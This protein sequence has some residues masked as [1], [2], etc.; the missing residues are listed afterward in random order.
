MAWYAKLNVAAVFGIHLVTR[1]SMF[2]RQFDP[3]DKVNW[4]HLCKNGFVIQLFK[5]LRKSD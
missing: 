4:N 5:G 3:I 2:F 1:F